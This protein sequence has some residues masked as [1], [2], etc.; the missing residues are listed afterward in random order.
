MN[1]KHFFKVAL[2]FCAVVA[3]GLIIMKILQSFN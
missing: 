1:L 3:V 2:S